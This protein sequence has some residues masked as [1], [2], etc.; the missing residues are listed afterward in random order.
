[1]RDSRAA[2]Q[3]FQRLREFIKAKDAKTL[4]YRTAVLDS[5]T[6]WSQAQMEAILVANNRKD[7]KAQIQDYGALAEE[8]R[9]LF[10][11]CVRAFEYVVLIAHEEIEKD[12]LTGSIVARPLCLGKKFVS[13]L[14][15]CVD[16]MWF[17]ESRVVANKRVFSIKTLPDSR[18]PFLRTAVANLPMTLEDATYEKIAKLGGFWTEPTT[19]ATQ[20]T[21]PNAAQAA[22]H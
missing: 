8:M 13:F 9:N 2:E 3:A 15:G 7:G 16:E 21:K 6:T 10:G 5:M 19:Q 22:T 14:P 11:M 12:E 4:P 17:C 20:P 18:H 1:M